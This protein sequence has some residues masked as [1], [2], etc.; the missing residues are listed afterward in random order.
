MGSLESVR[1][2][3]VGRW[4]AVA[5]LA[6]L[7]VRGI[8]GAASESSWLTGRTLQTRL[9]TVVPKQFWAGVRQAPLRKAIQT[10]A[11]TQ[12]VAILVDRRVDP[13]HPLDLSLS[14][15]TVGD[16]LHRIA[17]D[18]GLGLTRLGSVTYLGPPDVAARLRTLALLR[19]D[20]VARLPEEAEEALSRAEPLAWDDFA[21]PH[22]LLRRL[23]DSAGVRLDGL[24]QVPHDL[25]AAADL[26]A[27]SW[28]DRFTLIAVQFDL[29]FR[30]DSDGRSVQLV[31][32]PDRV[33][34]VRRYPGGKDPSQLAQRWSQLVPDSQIKVA[35]EDVFVRGLV[36]DHERLKATPRTTFRKP[37]KRSSSAARQAVR[38]S[39]ENAKGPL[40][41]LVAE[42]AQKL[43]VEVRIDR[44]AL[45]EAGIST[46]QEV[47]FSVREATVDELF[48]AVLRPAGC[49]F[50][51]EGK[52]LVVV[53]AR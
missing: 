41:R 28:V 35:G 53:P 29:T 23:A 48:E 31:P 32:I 1:G 36:E 39:V 33:A 49:T 38:F 12:R 52:T 17:E 21:T 30:I 43:Q 6:G 34:I 13:D 18:R 19:H 4:V 15:M 20:D 7:I 24:D 37:P 14:D 3:V 50:R 10:I 47:S 16:L 22:E 42:L 25:W 46:S 26:P 51:R 5:V 2:G 40:D 11:A 8:Q 45:A 9:D 44:D 27:L